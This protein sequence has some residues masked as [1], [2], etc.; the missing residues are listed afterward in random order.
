ME[1]TMKLFTPLL[2]V[3]LFSGADHLA[4]QPKVEARGITSKIQRRERAANA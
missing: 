2:F 3:V 1:K 4:A